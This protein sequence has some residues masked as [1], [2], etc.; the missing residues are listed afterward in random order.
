MDLREEEKGL[1]VVEPSQAANK[2]LADL[3][4]A[5]VHYWLM[6]WRGGEKVFESILKIFPN[7]D[8]YTLFYDKQTCAPY[9]K[10][11]KVYTSSLNLPF[12]KN[13]Y[14]KLFPFYPFAVKSLRLRKKYDL[15]I[16]SESGP[17]KGI[18]NPDNIPHVCYI[19]SPMRYC[20]G[21][22]DIYLESLPKWT[23]KIAK[24]RFQKLRQ[25]DETTIDNVD[26]YIANSQ[27]V[28][29]RVQK[30]YKRDADV[31]FPPIELDL[32]NTEPGG[33]KK[34]YYLSFGALTP[35]KNI[36]LLI[37]TFNQLDKK[38]VVIGSG[39]EK[40]KLESIA[41]HNIEFK[42]S[43]PLPEVINYIQQAKALLF[44]GEE[45]FGMIPLEVMSQ[46][47]PVIAL[48]KG[49]ALE[50]V[51]ENLEKPEESSG[52]FFELPNIHSLLNA[53]EKFESMEEQFDLH[54]IKQHARK[55][56]EDFF[57]QCFKQLVQKVL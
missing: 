9:L 18:A 45:D 47:V 7:A 51:V 19:H 54:W 14:Q 22:T 10:G 8:I 20:W 50:T 16:S 30:Y 37:N 11:R 29:N 26:L 21:F 53:I 12:L 13:Q 55:F 17:A 40:S 42:G 36:E 52:I 33:K 5:V 46:G 56:G 23:R 31:C 39:S 35:Y 32:F 15:I 3:K 28:K 48:S 49:G 34:D 41:N 2:N 24:W 43:L 57:Q 27:N 6:T 4:V 1:E 44:P 25:W 38:L